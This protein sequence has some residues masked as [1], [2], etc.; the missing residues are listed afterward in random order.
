M[1]LKETHVD[2]ISERQEREINWEDVR[3]FLAVA[4]LGSIRAAADETGLSINAL[5]RRIE[6]LE[7][8]TNSVLFARTT[9]GT[10][11]TE[12]G[13][14][15]RVA[16]EAMMQQARVLSHISQRQKPGLRSVVR[17]GITEGLGTFWLIPRVL[18]FCTAQ[19][20]IQVDLRCEM[21]PPNIAGLEVDFAVQLDRPSDLDLIVTRLGWLHICLF[22][23]DRYTERYGAPRTRAEVSQHAFIELVA[24]QIPSNKLE[25]DITADDKRAFVGLRVNTS[26]AQV[27]AVTN[28]GGV[29]ALPTYARALT[30]RLVHVATDFSVRRD[31]WLAYHPQAA[32]LPHV[33]KAIEWV[34]RCFDPARYVWFREEYIAPDDIARILGED[35]NDKLFANFEYAPSLS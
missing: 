34:R 23:S 20:M 14:K 31:I 28:G 29:T 26:S 8:E 17:I 25:E 32:E 7:R 5:R 33:R 9:K 6:E 2:T 4:R 16:G 19:P 13:R 22:A 21:K 12:E 27:L 15:V 18:E 3:L 10:V 35:G 1:L 30:S 11:L 24:D